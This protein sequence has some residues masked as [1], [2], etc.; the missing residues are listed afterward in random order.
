MTT[1]PSAARRKLATILMIDVAG[2]SRLIER[3]EEGTTALIREF[4]ER[5][6]GLVEAHQGR[7]VD[8]AVPQEPDATS[9]SRP[10]RS[11]WPSPDAAQVRRLRRDGPDPARRDVPALIGLPGASPTGRPSW[12]PAPGWRGS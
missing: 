5:T 7:V 11:S 9:A 10:M 2:F 3:N 4:H 1:E 12:T 8:T 6:R